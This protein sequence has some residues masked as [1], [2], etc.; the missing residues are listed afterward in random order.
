MRSIRYVEAK[1]ALIASILVSNLSVVIWNA[2]KKDVFVF[3]KMTH[4]VDFGIFS[5]RMIVKERIWFSE[6]HGES[7]E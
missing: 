4:N 3:G 1:T 6:H 2:K 7:K 5:N